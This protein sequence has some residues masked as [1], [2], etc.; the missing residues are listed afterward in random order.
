MTGERER[1]EKAKVLRENCQAEG[2]DAKNR[3]SMV[4]SPFIVIVVMII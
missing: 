1:T 4:L 2:N 3:C